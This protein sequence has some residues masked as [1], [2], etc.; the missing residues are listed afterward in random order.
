MLPATSPDRHSITGMS[1]RLYWPVEALSG[2]VA[3]VGASGKLHAPLVS[4][5]VDSDGTQR[6]GQKDGHALARH[7]KLRVRYEAVRGGRFKASPFGAHAHTSLWLMPVL[8][9][10]DMKAAGMG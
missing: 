6:L 4:V 8:G 1:Q 3:T 9:L 5:R 10:D 2:R 7:A